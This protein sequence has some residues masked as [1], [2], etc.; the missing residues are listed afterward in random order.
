[1]LYVFKDIN[2]LTDSDF[3]LLRKYLSNERLEKVDKYK[4]MVDKK[5][6]LI[7]YIMLRY[8]LYNEYNI[9]VKPI[10]LYNKYYKPSLLGYPDIK[11]NI[12]HCKNGVVCVVS[13]KDI[14]CDIQ[15]IDK[16]SILLSNDIFSNNEIIKIRNSNDIA[17][18]FTQMWSI[19]ESYFK[20]IGTGLINSINITDFSTIK[21]SISQKFDNRLIYSFKYVDCYI[22]VCYEDFNFNPKPKILKYNDFLKGEYY[23][24][25][26]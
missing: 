14:G 16:K 17:E 6:S 22:S 24:F 10:F 21:E 13:N 1:M 3:Y 5:L 15:N 20:C 12:S 9:Q 18:T 23:E 19:K 8:A 11:F 2:R 26:K 7:A 25:E 4:F